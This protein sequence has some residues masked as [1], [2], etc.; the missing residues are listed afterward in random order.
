M[1]H[2]QVSKTPLFFCSLIHS[3][4]HPNYHP[5]HPFFP[6]ALPFICLSSADSLHPSLH[7]R[8]SLQSS[9]SH[10]L[11]HP[12]ASCPVSLFS[13]TVLSAL[14]VSPS[15]CLPLTHFSHQSSCPSLA[16]PPLHLIFVIHSSHLHSSSLL[17]PTWHLSIHSSPCLSVLFLTFASS[18]HVSHLIF[19]LSLFELVPL[20]PQSLS[21][22]SY[23]T[24]FSLATSLCL[25]CSILLMYL[26][27]RKL[28]ETNLKER[29][30]SN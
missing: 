24:F 10:P 28:N 5:S 6:Q 19:S 23:P 2:T 20:C 25:S 22:P 13:S 7:F 27:R 4:F 17:Y 29:F 26:Y 3:F 8:P 21:L 14:S 11:P 16:L 30:C 18:A 12:I 9:L 15:V 1:W